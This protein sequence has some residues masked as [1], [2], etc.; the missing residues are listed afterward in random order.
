MLRAAHAALTSARPHFLR[1]F[2]A[3]H[4]HTICH[5]AVASGCDRDK[6]IAKCFAEQGSFLNGSTSELTREQTFDIFATFAEEV[7]GGKV[8]RAGLVEIAL[9]RKPVDYYMKAW[10][11][12]KV[13]IATGVMG[14]PKHVIDGSVLTGTDSEWEVADYKAKLLALPVAG[15]DAGKQTM[16]MAAVVALAAAAGAALALLVSKRRCS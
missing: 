5:A 11:E 12:C 9:T 15:R 10:A 3:F 8:S 14:S 16:P 6:Y 13:G 7:S 1:H 4:A 2:S